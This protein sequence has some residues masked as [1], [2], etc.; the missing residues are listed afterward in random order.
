MNITNEQ[1]GQEN[2]II[3]KSKKKIIMDVLYSIFFMC[4]I[5]VYF[6]IV[7]NKYSK[8]EKLPDSISGV[9]V[10]IILTF[11]H[12]IGRRL[13]ISRILI[14]CAQILI[15]FAWISLI[16]QISETQIL[17]I[18]GSCGIIS[19]LYISISIFYLFKNRNTKEFIEIGQAGI[20]YRSLLINNTTFI[21]WNDIKKITMPHMGAEPCIFIYLKNETKK[22]HR[23]HTIFIDI[24][25]DELFEL[26]QL[27]ME[28]HK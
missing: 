14:F 5:I 25:A 28:N 21:K 23:I 16:D 9:C 22:R 20:A 26:L 27:Q 7:Y 8:G 13:P 10:M 18:L 4:M 17:L 15:L 24:D 1:I 11:D 3:Q 2:I 12:I 19:F 6:F